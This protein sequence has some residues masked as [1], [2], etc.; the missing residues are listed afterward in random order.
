MNCVDN[1]E[2]Y[3]YKDSSNQSYSAKTNSEIDSA[4]VD[5]EESRVAEKFATETQALNDKYSATISQLEARG[6]NRKYHTH[7]LNIFIALTKKLLE[8]TRIKG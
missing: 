5:E 3:S 7:S 8:K 6:L 1:E 2:A 4:V